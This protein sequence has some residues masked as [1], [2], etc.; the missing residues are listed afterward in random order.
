MTNF[1]KVSVRASTLAFFLFSAFASA[2]DRTPENSRAMEHP[3][4][5]SQHAMPAESREP[6]SPSAPSPQSMPMDHGDMSMQ[7]GPPPPDARDPHAYAGG[8]DRGPY[9]LRLADE[10]NFFA[11]LAD[12]LESVRT[13]DESAA[14]YDLQV[15]F[16]RDYDRAVF[17]AEGDVNDGKL[18]DARTELLWG[19]AVAAYWDAQ[20]GVRV[21]SGE[22]PNRNWL[23][24]GVQGL[25][26]YWFEVEASGYVGEN[27][28]TA[29]RLQAS[30]ELLFTQRL[31]LQP[32]IEANF[33]GKS[34][35]ER[36][37]GSGLSEA[38]A[39]LRLRYEIRREFAPYVGVVWARKFGGTED[40][41][42]AAG[43][44]P[45]ETSVVAGVRFWF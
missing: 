8:Y 31:V 33:Y 25:A 19:H 28:R 16:G 21:D 10:H 36:G 2:Q 7:G 1:T 6:A 14:E 22:G 29:L 15:W 37:L 40:I 45:R 13:D 39:G 35:V 41:A 3:I 32:R 23:A 26:P 34:D 17:K 20:L 44:D 24:F 12:R 11:L 43:G 42:R 9:A 4:D 38:A 5:H 30:Y 18:E 27:R